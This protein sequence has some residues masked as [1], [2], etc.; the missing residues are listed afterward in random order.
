MLL[1]KI[2]NSDDFEMMCYS[3]YTDEE[4]VKILEDA[5]A[6]MEANGEVEVFKALEERLNKVKIA[7]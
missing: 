1:E 3:G 4:V 6:E 7:M 2:F 5:K